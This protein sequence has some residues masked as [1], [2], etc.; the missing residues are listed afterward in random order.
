MGLILC[1][2]ILLSGIRRSHF[3]FTFVPLNIH[4]FH[5]PV[6]AFLQTQSA[7]YR[8]PGMDVLVGIFIDSL[9]GIKP[10]ADSVDDS[11]INAAA[12]YYTEVEEVGNEK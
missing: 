10:F 12:F 9:P 6:L 7:M 11:G 2:L 5:R 4:D 1:R 3:A 8:R